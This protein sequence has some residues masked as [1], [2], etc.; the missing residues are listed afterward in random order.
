M[1]IVTAMTISLLTACGGGM[2]PI[3]IRKVTRANIYD[4]SG[5]NLLRELPQDDAVKIIEVMTT[6]AT[7]TTMDY[8]TLA[9]AQTAGKS[10]LVNLIYGD[11][12]FTTV[13]IIPEMNYFALCDNYGLADQLESQL[14]PLF[15]NLSQGDLQTA[16]PTTT[17]G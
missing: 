9:N 4:H 3:G 15:A 5:T 13:Y 2:L 12:T 14:A 8:G 6:G 16:A 11:G 10:F 1:A 17:I 7:P